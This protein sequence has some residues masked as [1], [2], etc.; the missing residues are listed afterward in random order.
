LTPSIVALKLVFERI[1]VPLFE[2]FG[3]ELTPNKRMERSWSAKRRSWLL[4]GPASILAKPDPDDCPAHR[5]T[6]DLRR[7]REREH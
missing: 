5:D 4:A 2:A 1:D 7:C 6:L 3:A